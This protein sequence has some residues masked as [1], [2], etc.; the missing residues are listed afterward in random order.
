VWV[1]LGATF[2]IARPRRSFPDGM[3]L[4][5]TVPGELSAWGIPTTG[6]W[7]GYVSFSI[8]EAD[9][10]TRVSQWVLAGALEPRIDSPARPEQRQT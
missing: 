7:V 10:G 2:R 6:H 4:Q 9:A 5:A 8:R 3:D 1:D